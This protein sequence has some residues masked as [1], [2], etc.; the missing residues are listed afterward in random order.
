M[1]GR[2]GRTKNQQVS[3]MS[4][5]L[6]Q[7]S[8]SPVF[9]HVFGHLPARQLARASSGV[10]TKLGAVQNLATGRVVRHGR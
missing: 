1:A 4:R 8:K 2:I 7:M 6:A 3:E 5:Q 9:L 10:G